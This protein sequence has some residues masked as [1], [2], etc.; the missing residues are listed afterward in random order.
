MLAGHPDQMQGDMT[1]QCAKVTAG[2]NCSEPEPDAMG[3]ALRKDAHE[4]RLLLQVP[5]A[6]GLGMLW[7]DAGCLY[8]WIR[9]KDLRAR[10]FDRC[11]LVLQGG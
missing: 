5:S 11:W 2:Y 10:R 8:Y 3:A 7:G 4:W 1:L 6:E 9:E